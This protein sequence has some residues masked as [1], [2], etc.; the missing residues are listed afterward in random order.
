MFLLFYA[1]KHFYSI[2]FQLNRNLVGNIPCGAVKW[3]KSYLQKHLKLNLF[4]KWC[5]F[6]LIRHLANYI[7]NKTKNLQ[8]VRCTLIVMKWHRNFYRLIL[9]CYMQWH[10][11]TPGKVLSINHILWRQSLF[12]MLQQFRGNTKSWRLGN[13]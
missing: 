1:G 6:V 11:N 9:Q 13:R 7:C 5:L 3:L 4:W 8:M 2:N 12:N 10:F